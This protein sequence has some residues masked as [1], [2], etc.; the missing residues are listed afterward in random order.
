LLAYSISAFVRVFGEQG[1]L[2][3]LAVFGVTAFVGVPV[4]FGVGS[5]AFPA[6]LRRA[7]GVLGEERGQLGL[8]G[9]LVRLAPCLALLALAVAVQWSLVPQLIGMVSARLLTS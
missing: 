4:L 3:A 9:Q 5:A 7:A 8:R 1:I 6:S 2:G